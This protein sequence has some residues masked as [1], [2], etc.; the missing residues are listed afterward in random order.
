[1]SDLYDNVNPYGSF[2]VW[3]STNIFYRR[4][5]SF[6]G[7]SVT[8][9]LLKNAGMTPVMVDIR[10]A[11][12]DS[13]I[14]FQE[15]RRQLMLTIYQAEGQ[16][17]NLYFTQE[18]IHFYDDSV[19]AAQEMWMTARKKL[20]AGQG[21]VEKDVME[22]QSAL[23]LRNTK[24]NDAVQNYYD[25]LGHLQNFAG[26]MPNPNQPASGSPMFRVVD[27]PYTT[28]SPPTYAET[29]KKGYS[30]NPDYLIQQEKMNQ[31]RLH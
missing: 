10:L 13:K 15:Y 18:Q 29:F 9:P 22:A 11:A 28:N 21:R 7:V 1:M 17:W 23:A 8:Q 27:N 4:I 12:L 3:V 31:E 19:S 16:Y 25:A 30:L 24:R 2:L 14:A 5:Q 20:K 26:I 6:A